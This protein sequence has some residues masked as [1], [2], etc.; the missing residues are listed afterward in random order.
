MVAEVAQQT[1]GSYRSD[2]AAVVDCIE[3][4]E[5]AQR[6]GIALALYTFALHELAI[7]SVVMMPGEAVQENAT[8]WAAWRIWNELWKEHLRVKWATTGLHPEDVT[9][10]WDMEWD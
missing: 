2:V 4:E 5:F 7:S 8:S 9:D 1:D 10:N 6:R 3:V